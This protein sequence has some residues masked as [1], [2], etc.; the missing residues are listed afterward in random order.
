M[1]MLMLEGF[2]GYGEVGDQQ[3]GGICNGQQWTGDSA[4]AG[5]KYVDHDGRG[6]AK[7]FGGYN[8][9]VQKFFH[10]F[11]FSAANVTCGV[12]LFTESAAA[13]E[14]ITILGLQVDRTDFA[15]GS[16]LFARITTNGT[17]WIVR[18]E[19]TGQVFDSGISVVVEQYTYFELQVELTSGSTANLK[20]RIN[21]ATVVDTAV[22]AGGTLM[23]RASFELTAQYG[24]AEILIDDFYLSDQ[25]QFY[26]PLAI[27]SVPLAQATHQAMSAVGAATP[28]LCVDEEICD[29]DA[30]YITSATPGAKQTFTGTF[31]AAPLFILLSSQTRSEAL[32][33]TGQRFIDGPDGGYREGATGYYPETYATKPIILETLYDGS[34]LSQAGANAQEFGFEIVNE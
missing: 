14:A 33:A 34:P 27:K 8:S 21:G 15:R 28:L 26:G 11:V 30:T 32:S 4:A 29:I 12:S 7:K 20:A 24:S 19:A 17:N 23:H 2:E 16:N 9:S 3:S 6:V 22:A 5:A 1:T 18:C 31:D 10:T 13:D 25:I